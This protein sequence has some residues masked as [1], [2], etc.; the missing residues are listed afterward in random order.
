VAALRQDE[1]QVQQA[2]RHQMERLRYQAR[3]AERQST[4]V[5]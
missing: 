1:E 5:Y 2:Q 4:A 3:L